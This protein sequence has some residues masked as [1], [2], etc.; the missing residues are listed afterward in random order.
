MG[1]QDDR[2][3][4]SD[5]RELGEE[6]RRAR[7]DTG[8]TLRQLQ[9]HI[10]AGR[11]TLARLENGEI[12]RPAVSIVRELDRFLGGGG[13]WTL[14]AERLQGAPP[15]PQTQW[16]HLFPS[17]H[18]G[19]V[20]VTLRPARDHVGFLHQMTLRWGP[21]ALD[22]R[23]RPRAVG[24]TWWFSKR[25]ADRVPMRAHVSPPAWLHFEVH[26]SPPQDAIDANGGWVDTEHAD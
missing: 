13:R 8:L 1:Q 16:L 14:A 12:R 26:D 11:S 10:T 25:F 2:G 23:A 18:T 6:L 15:P 20:S 19:A 4:P 3:I 21:W 5:P 24:Q 7:E 17:A 9:Q 22:L